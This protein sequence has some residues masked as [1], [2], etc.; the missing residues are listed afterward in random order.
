MISNLLLGK[1]LSEDQNREIGYKV[2]YIFN[3]PFTLNLVN[4]EYYQSF[5]LLKPIH[6]YLTINGH[7]VDKNKLKDTISSLCIVKRCRIHILKV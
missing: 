5:I 1:Q 6:Q 2:D 3:V 7:Y 4:N